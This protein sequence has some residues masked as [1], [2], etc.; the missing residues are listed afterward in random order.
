ML[1]RTRI[2]LMVVFGLVLL[3]LGLGAAGLLREQLLLQRLSASLQAAQAMQWQQTLAMQQRLLERLHDG[4]QARHATDPAAL[5]RLLTQ[6]QAD[7]PGP[8]QLELLALL[9][10]GREPVQAGL[11][12]TSKL[13]DSASLERV[14]AGEPLSGLRLP[15]EGRALMLSARRLPG[16]GEPTVLVLGHDAG[17]LL[18]QLAQSGAGAA[19]LIDLRGR[20]LAS[21]APALWQAAAPQVALRIAEQ[22]TLRLNGQE[23]TAISLPVQDLAGHTVATL[24]TLSEHGAEARASRFLGLLA[25][26]GTLALL[27][28]IALGLNLYL[29]LSLRPLEQAIDALQGLAQ[30]NT[31]VQL[32]WSGNDE[33]GRIAQAVTSF[34]RTL[35]ELQATRTLRERVRRRQERLLRTRLQELAQ[36]THQSI[37]PALLGS[38]S[39]SDEEQ[40]RQLAAVMNQL[41]TRLID[42]HQRLSGMVQELRE[43]LISK[44]RLAGLEQELQIAAQ[45][46][47]SILPQHPPGDARVALHSQIIP[48]REVGG[49]F[50]DYFLVGPNQL[51]FVM[52]DVSGKG[53]PAAL[54]MTITRTLLKATAQ[55]ISDPTPCIE[56]LNRLLAAENEQ[57]MFVT[58]FYGVLD[59]R[60]GQVDYVNAGHNPP[61]LLR[62]GHPPKPL[63]R[64]GSMALAVLED[65]PYS[66]AQLTL[67]PGEQIFL[68]TDGVTEA[69]NAERQE[70]GEERL[71]QLLARLPQADPQAINQAVVDDVHAFE[72]GAPQA[73]DIT[74]MTLRWKDP[75]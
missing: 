69:M 16:Q 59:L 8:I 42:Q 60:S 54:F 57:M 10:P 58:L 25:L 48:A 38:D 28:A 52:A 22:R 55:F 19:S 43:A 71:V 11:R 13:L 12:T 62:P 29:R 72:N 37:G 6:T 23:H 61:Y 14:L 3:A 47:L 75:A 24:V 45:V 67:A 36:A 1:L 35:Q 27:L 68:F 18:Q 53:V 64:T 33:I 4:L 7:A 46:Q 30:G 40:L 65:A 56:Q 21:T 31:Q 44:D 39:H 26:G 50:Y 5:D 2:T 70:Y 49:D 17:Q 9:Q 63:P 34:R 73:D 66:S 51:G 41:G 32:P 15:G 74:C 20:L